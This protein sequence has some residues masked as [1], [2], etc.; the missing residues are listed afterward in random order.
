MKY[1]SLILLSLML[2]GC[3]CQERI[4]IVEVKIP[5]PVQPPAPPVIEK[6]ILSSDNVSIEIDGYDGLVKSIQRDF[7]LMKSYVNN[8]ERVLNVYR[9]DLIKSRE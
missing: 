8:L 6:P 3:A 7:V 5:V 4:K 2:T 1:F 9:E